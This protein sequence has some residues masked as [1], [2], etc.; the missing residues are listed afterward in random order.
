[1]GAPRGLFPFLL[2]P[3]YQL[4]RSQ[5]RASRRSHPVITS[6][7]QACSREPPGRGSCL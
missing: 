3:P 1:M 6:S 4:V 2:R 5:V 7:S